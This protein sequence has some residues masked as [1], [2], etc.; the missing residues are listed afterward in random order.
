V[1]AGR[2]ALAPGDLLARGALERLLAEGS[3]EHEQLVVS[4]PPLEDAPESPYLA[5]SL[6]A[7]L[8]VHRARTLPRARVAAAAERLRAAGARVIGAVFLE[9]GRA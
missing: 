5:R 1:I 3:G 9:G 8:L 4:L 6:D 7:V 2:S